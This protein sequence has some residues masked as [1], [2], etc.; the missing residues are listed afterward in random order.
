MAT[1]E[2]IVWRVAVHSCGRAIKITQR[3]ID[4]G[5]SLY[6]LCEASRKSWDGFLLDGEEVLED[7]ATD[8]TSVVV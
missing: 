8:A 6:C 2:A 3:Y 1:E 7:V 5:V 4:K